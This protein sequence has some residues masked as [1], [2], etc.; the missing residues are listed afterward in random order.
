MAFLP[1]P[2]AEAADAS[3]R[4]EAGGAS[5]GELRSPAR[6]EGTAP[7]DSTQVTRQ[8]F[9]KQ[10]AHYVQHAVRWFFFWLLQTNRSVGV[11]VCDK[12]S[13]QFRML[14]DEL[15]ARDSTRHQRFVSRVSLPEAS[16]ASFR[17]WPFPLAVSCWSTFATIFH[18]CRPIRG[19]RT[20]IIF[21]LGLGL[22]VDQATLPFAKALSF[23]SRTRFAFA[24]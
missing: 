13:G 3:A 19:T 22:N 7:V 24:S 17:L 18:L 12:T 21:I 15:T 14:S 8:S 16:S 5:W 10:E 2:E 9:G 1:F 6:E 20:F 23:E 4:E 11:C